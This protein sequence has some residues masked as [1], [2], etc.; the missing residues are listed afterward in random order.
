MATIGTGCQGIYTPECREREYRLWQLSSPR[1]I[2]YVSMKPSPTNE[3][4][5][6]LRAIGGGLAGATLGF[7]A[8]YL[9]YG[10]LNPILEARDDWLE[11]FQGALFNI[12]PL[13]IVIGAAAGWILVRR[14]GRR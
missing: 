3:R 1:H 6:S 2:L 13:C 11:E 12:V 7:G 14:L 4:P 10:W 5:L 9:I 8:G